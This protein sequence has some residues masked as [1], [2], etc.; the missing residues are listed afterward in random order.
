MRTKRLVAVFAFALGL[1]CVAGIAQATEEAKTAPEPP[2]AVE[3][4]VSMEPPAPTEEVATDAASVCEEASTSDLE[5]D[6]SA[7]GP[8]CKP[9]K[10]RTWCKCTY[11]GFPRASCDPCCYVNDI[12]VRICL[13]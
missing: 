11:N 5:S 4:A 10:G 12:G 13:D 8:G 6:P 2:P 3:P 7:A 1:A 9:C